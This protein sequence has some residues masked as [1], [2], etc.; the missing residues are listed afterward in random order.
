MLQRYWHYLRI[1]LLASLILWGGYV[2]IAFSGVPVHGAVMLPEALQ[3]STGTGCAPEAFFCRGMTALLP[4]IWYGVSRWLWTDKNSFLFTFSLCSALIVAAGVF[5]QR[6]RTQSSVLH[7]TVS[8]LRT[9]AV[10]IG[11]LWLL[12]TTMSFGSVD[13]APYRRIYEPEQE[14]YGSIGSEALQAL[15]NNF[16]TLKDRGCLTPVGTTSTGGNAYSLSGLCM[17]GAF[18]SRVLP[19]L[20]LLL[21]FGFFCLTLGGAVLRRIGVHPVFPAVA[22]PLS[23]GAGACMLVA[24][25]WTVAALKIYSPLIVLALLLLLVLALMLSKDFRASVRL[26][27]TRWTVELSW[28]DV[29]L[30]LAWLLLTYLALNFLSV[31]RPFPIGWDDLG[32]YL[33]KPRQLVSYGFLI[34]QMGSFQWEYLTSLS[35]LLLGYDNTFAA[36]Q[37]M[38]INW[39]AGAL[40]VLSVFAFCRMFL[41]RGAWLAAVLYYVLPLVGHFSF[42]DM[43]ID[44][45]V[46]AMG[47]FAF[48]CMFIGLFGD[49]DERA[50]TH[51]RIWFVVAGA[52]AGFAFGMK[53]TAVMVIMSLLAIASGAFLGIA[54]FLGAGLGAFVVFIKTALRLPDVIS[55]FGLSPETFTPSLIIGTLALL[56]IILLGYGLFRHKNKAGQWFLSCTLFVIGVIATAAPWLIYNNVAA[57]VS[58]PSVLLNPPNHMMADIN[59]E[60]T[61]P[62]TAN[63]RTLPPELKVDVQKCYATATAKTEELDRYWGFG[64]GWQHYAYLPWRSV[65]NIDSAGYYITTMPALLLFPLL[66]LLPFFWSTRGRWLRW[67]WAGS[68]LLVVQWIFLANGI[69][70]YGIGMFLGLSV[71]LAALA[72]EGPDRWTRW[73]A[74]SLLAVSIIFCLSQRAWQFNNMRNLY[75]FPLGKVSAEAMQERTIPH[76]DDVRDLILSRALETPEAP[77]VFRVGTFIPYFIPKNMEYLPVADNQLE[78][79]KCLYMER[80][81]ALT[82][83]RLKTLGFNSII[84][85]TNTFTIERDPNGTLHQKVYSFLDFVNHTELGM[86]IVVNDPENG[87]AFILLP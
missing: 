52:F 63:F 49:D 7:L 82:L 21:L 69:P 41:P 26:L 62:A 66:L 30:L 61:E 34:P 33:N 9:V 44:N 87:I 85:D 79:F 31:I 59:L 58:S 3:S 55:R 13:G 81:A 74:G 29:R 28:Y 35:F 22:V 68:A 38:V 36:T 84:F 77:F 54:G 65:M 12:F 46:F 8:P 6:R 56:T 47:A 70:W 18:F 48:L 76:Y 78:I 4:S 43:K 40:A 37:A 39:G 75:E 20:G 14:V 57:G 32:V 53:A 16:A 71:T 73:T 60:S 80:D 86:K 25:L 1:G 45:A 50:L 72:T 11:V 23:I 51:A 5:W 24:M 67:L 64:T 10:F 83:K 15:Q 27:T 17:Q 19:Q 42:A 2:T